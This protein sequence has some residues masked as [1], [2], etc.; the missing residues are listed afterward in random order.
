MKQYVYQF[1]KGCAE[2]SAAMSDNLGGK[3]ANLAEM[4]N[5]NIQKLRD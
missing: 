2:G 1:K 4:S 5:L 3:G